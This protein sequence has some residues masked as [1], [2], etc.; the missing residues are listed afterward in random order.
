[1]DLKR[2]R[3]TQI[4]LAIAAALLCSSAR[5]D[6][7]D[8]KTKADDA[9]A[10][11][12]QEYCAAAHSAK[13]SARDSGILWKVWGAV[14]SVCS[15][16]C[17]RSLTGAPLSPMICS[18]AS[19]AAG[20]T[21]GLMTKN[22]A[23]ALMA[24]G[25]SAAGGAFN[26]AAG[27][28]EK[29]GKPATRKK[30]WGACMSAATAAFQA[31]TKHQVAQASKSSYETNLELAR[32]LASTAEDGNGAAPT[33]PTSANAPALPDPS[34]ATS[35]ISFDGDPVAMEADADSSRE[36]ACANAKDS[37]FQGYVSCATALDQHVPS[38]AGSPRFADEFKKASGQDLAEFMN[39]PEPGE[40]GPAL[41]SAMG[42]GTLPS[43]GSAKLGEVVAQL[44]QALRARDPDVDGTAYAQ[45]GGGSSAG[46][47][48]AA[49]DFNSL[50]QGMMGQ[51]LPGHSGAKRP[52]GVSTASFGV[53]HS[54]MPA[55]VGPEDKRFSL[56]ERVR[57]RYSIV[58]PRMLE[59]AGGVE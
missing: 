56:F 10:A 6:V 59:R 1:M 9:N 45:G 16:A 28:I 36:N 40:I 22:F 43:Q 24:I 23:S 48:E 49:P 38:F 32:G 42:G 14:A 34:G 37:G 41:G 54:R 50:V 18:G 31:V 30:D 39:Q 52:N 5:A 8:T 27:S 57:I 17:L 25:S 51:F 19:V 26:R 29:N 55:S 3:Q 11:Q 35:T 33:P 21:D 20:V 46:H 15:F 7:C 12:R 4:S 58:G 13:L 53:A 2:K 47:E 44:D